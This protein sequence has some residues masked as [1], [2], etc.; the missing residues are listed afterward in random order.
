MMRATDARR[1]WVGGDWIRRGGVSRRDWRRGRRSSAR[2]GDVG[3][4]SADVSDGVMLSNVGSL[5]M[6]E[7]GRK[8]ADEDG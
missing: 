1:G 7:A 4:W 6:L 2:N 5:C 8:A 3:V